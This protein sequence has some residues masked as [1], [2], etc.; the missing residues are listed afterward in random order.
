MMGQKRQ[1]SIPTGPVLSLWLIAKTHV[2]L[3]YP[4][5]ELHL[6]RPYQNAPKVGDP[7]AKTTITVP[8]LHSTTSNVEQVH[9]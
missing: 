8:P 1:Q 2:K 4:V 7:R 5:A 3:I 6:I 9:I